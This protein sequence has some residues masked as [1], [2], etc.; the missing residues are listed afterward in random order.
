MLS[1]KEIAGILKL[2]T[3]LMEMYEA[4]QFK[5]RAYAGAVFQLEKT[6]AQVASLDKPA[7]VALGFSESMADK[8]L[9]LART[10]TLPELDELRQ[11]TPPGVIDMLS[12]KGLGAKKVKAIW[13]ELQVESLHELLEA[14]RAGKVAQLK[15]FG[16]KT[17]D[18]IIKEIDFRTA[19][20]DK[21]HYADAEAL[22]LE[23]EQAL[24]TS[25]LVKHLSLSGQIRLR[26]EVVDTVQLLAV[27]EDSEAL[28]T[29]LA[30]QAF[31]ETDAPRSSPFAWRG[32]FRS[33]DTGERSLRAEVK[34]TDEPH[35]AGELLLASAAPA[36]LA[37]AKLSRA[38]KS[39]A[40]ASE[41]AIYESVGLPYFAPEL[42]E[43]LFEFELAQ[44]GLPK[45]V[46][47]SDLRG[48]LHNH[49]TYSDGK[50]TLE[51][52]AL[53]CRDL[54]YEYLGIS[55]HSQSAFYANGLTVD[56]IQRQHEEIDRLNEK[57]AP[58]KIFKGIEADILN[59]GSLDYPDQVLATFDF[60]V[61]SI[62]S[63]L[64]MDRDKATQRLLRAIANPY[65]TILGH[66]TGRLLLRREGYPIDHEAIIEACAAHQVVIEIN[67]SPWRLDLDWR[68]VH[69][70]LARGV[71]T[72]I[73]PDA[74]EQEGYADMYYGLLVARKGGAE[75]KDVFNTL[76][77]AEIGEYFSQKR[78]NA[79]A[80]K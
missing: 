44:A 64:R 14:C 71:R 17:Q 63:N 20:S 15:G 65:T 79:K 45:L 18:A 32:Y 21:L 39:G 35:F 54:G 59:D 23:L 9:A 37:Q 75:K 31:L 3:S 70:A 29:F 68:W 30:S 11:Q 50:H 51:Q 8:L 28:R 26:A 61:A 76:G 58:F 2:T 66:P 77:Q 72:S 55:D 48:I 40:H 22:A 74:H 19:N 43:G 57:L 33:P 53:A 24:A 4:N 1:N 46:E 13:H 49:S 16:E 34:F 60:I 67:A 6:E 36:H 7:L 62:H 78:E 10:E 42:R 38:A 80:I 5:I 56:R 41:A 27:P 73:N 12:V 47:M 69:Q 52:M 25:G